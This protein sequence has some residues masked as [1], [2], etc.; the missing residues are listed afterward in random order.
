MLKTNPGGRVVNGLL[1]YTGVQAWPY[2]G[3]V[4]RANL[5]RI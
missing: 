2:P 5:G 3:H 1:L 4:F